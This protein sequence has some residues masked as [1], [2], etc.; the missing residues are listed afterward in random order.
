MDFRVGIGLD[1]HRFAPGRR[2]VLGGVDIPHEAGLL[3]H[4]DAD[5]ILHAV[6]DA[7]LGAAALGD[8]GRHFPPTE[9]RWREASSLLLLGQVRA[10]LAQAGYLP[11]QVDVAVVAERPKL[12][13]Y[14]PQM[15]R[16]I[17]A[18]LGIA[19]EAVSIKATTAE[20]MGALGRGEG[21][22]AWAVALIRRG[23]EDRAP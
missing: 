5:V 8:L 6:C 4:S 21:I 20:G 17:A 3:G 18:V 15:R 19:E 10:L 2:L 16:N 7:L 13:P 11:V 23:A 1:F 14:V 12:A 9:E 22:A